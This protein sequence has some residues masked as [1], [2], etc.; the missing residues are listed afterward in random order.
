MIRHI[1]LYTLDEL[2]NPVPCEDCHEWARQLANHEIKVVQQDYVGAAWVSTVFLGID[3]NFIGG[4]PPI[5]FETMVFG[6]HLIEGFKFMDRDTRRYATWRD[7]EIGHAEIIRSL[8][9]QL[10][11]A[12]KPAEIRAGHEHA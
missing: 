4:G 6:L 9:K 2:K 1:R 11:E 7:A 3:H 12:G 5:L 10:R 8:S